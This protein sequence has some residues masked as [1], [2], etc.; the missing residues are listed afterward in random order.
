MFIVGQKVV[1]IDGKFDPQIQKFYTAMPE[2]GRTYVVRSVCV[3]V[4]PKGEEGEIAVTLVGMKNPRSSTPPFPERGF[5][6]ERFRSL[7]EIQGR[8]TESKP[9]KVFADA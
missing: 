1:C 8:E 7:E 3:G 4:S 9:E 2:E 5:K 6:A